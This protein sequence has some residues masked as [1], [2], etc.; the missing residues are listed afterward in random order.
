M[1]LLVEGQVSNSILGWVW[2]NSAQ[3]YFIVLINVC[4]L[5]MFRRVPLKT[6]QAQ[7][8][9]DYSFINEYVFLSEFVLIFRTCRIGSIRTPKNDNG[10]TFVLNKTSK[11]IDISVR[12]K[13]RLRDTITQTWYYHVCVILCITQT[14]NLIS[15]KFLTLKK[16]S[17]RCA[18][19]RTLLIHTFLQ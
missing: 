17:A 5:N 15:G 8:W 12:A 3:S 18:L 16:M 14:W 2:P 13:S 19:F 10:S 11:L 6:K 7:A 1:W 9:A 4:F